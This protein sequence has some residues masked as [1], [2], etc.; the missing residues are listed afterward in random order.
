MYDFQTCDLPPISAALSPT[1]RCLTTRQANSPSARRLQRQIGWSTASARVSTG[2]AATTP[3]RTFFCMA[4]PSPS[5]RFWSAPA[6]SLITTSGFRDVY[7]IGRIN[8]PDA[9][10]LYF[11]KHKPLIERAL[12][13]ELRERIRADG[14]VAEPLDEAGL[15]ALNES[16]EKL[17]IEAAA[18]MFIN[19][20]AQCRARDA[21]EGA[22]DQASSEHVHQRIA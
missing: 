22:S 18:I 15:A 4:P 6:P 1:S 14:E 21:R 8:R 3:P 2:P 17:G 13:F 12:R 5:T 20:Y 16:L 10:N 9:Y 19:C 7:E 11:Q